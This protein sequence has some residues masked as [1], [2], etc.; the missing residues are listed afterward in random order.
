M[1]RSYEIK[2]MVRG[3][4]PQELGEICAALQSQW[5]FDPSDFPLSE[6]PPP[7]EL[8]ACGVDN[9]CGG[10]SADEMADRLAHAVWAA[11]GAYCQV[12]V[13]STFLDMVPPEEWQES[14]GAEHDDDKRVDC[15]QE[16]D[17]VPRA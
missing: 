9:L 3:Y 14:G 1:S 15:V 5:D 17:G 6:E 13:W 12:E 16:A 4:R 10:M 8:D 2:V 11:N 7:A